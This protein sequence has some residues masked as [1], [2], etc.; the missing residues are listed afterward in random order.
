MSSVHQSH[1][2][3]FLKQ[4]LH[5]PFFSTAPLPTHPAKLP[6]PA[7][8]L[9]P[10]ALAPD[11]NGGGEGKKRKAGPLMDGLEEKAGKVARKLDF[12]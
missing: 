12:S 8:E 10:R 5:H 3:Q 6:K 11:Q 9:V 1:S 2:D 7:G 4:A